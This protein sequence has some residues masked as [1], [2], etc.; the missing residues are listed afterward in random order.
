MA[1]L[2]PQLKEA[3]ET[4]SPAFSPAQLR[5]LVHLTER[6]LRRRKRIR[7]AGAALGVLL[8]VSGAVLFLV[9]RLPVPA[10]PSGDEMAQVEIAEGGGV[11]VRGI[12]S[13]RTVRFDTH[14]T[15]LEL[16]EG[17][18]RFS[19]QHQHGR[20]VRVQSGHIGVEVIGTIFVIERQAQDVRVQ[21]EE[22][23]VQVFRNEHLERAVRAGE[24]AL[25]DDQEQPVAPPLGPVEEQADTDGQPAAEGE[26]AQA[27]SSDQ[28][29]DRLATVR[30]S[31][32]R[33]TAKRNDPKNEE[34]RSLAAKGAFDAAWLAMKQSQ[35]RDEPEDLLRAAD[36]ARLSG[37]A[38]E[39]VPSLNRVLSHFSS[40][41]RS[42][43]AAFTLGRVLLEDLASPD[44]AAQAF[45]KAQYLSPSGPL[46]ADALARE[47]ESLSK[48]GN[49][50]K[51][52][53]RAQA[54]L[55]R[56]PNGPNVASVK[57][58]GHLR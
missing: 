56:Y 16:P 9:R 20:R 35:P 21:V 27:T 42:P 7:A 36:V 51:A 39:A 10:Q 44:A 26:S 38:R 53:E 34:W 5:R 50:E 29:R 18:A 24:T 22:G 47:V 3:A 43:L 2:I 48:A 52:T 49:V 25:F 1:E 6:R 57:R 15:V 28:T 12:S 46:A 8:V 55:S 32:R 4:L 33:N 11:V 41:A 23:A 30:R 17:R 54:Y 37:H 14:H 45:A 19:V 13:L 40:D 31:S 58:W